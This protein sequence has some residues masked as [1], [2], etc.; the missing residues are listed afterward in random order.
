MII[1][2]VKQQ[3]SGLWIV[4]DSSGERHATRSAF[5]ATLAERYRAAKTSVD[6]DSYRGWY[7]RDLRAITPSPVNASC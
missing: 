6:I 4:R 5:L 2:E 1:V 7:Y 3:P